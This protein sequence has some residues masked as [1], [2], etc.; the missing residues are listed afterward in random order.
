MLHKESSSSLNKKT[1]LFVQ[2]DG[3]FWVFFLNFAF[4][5]GF[6][7]HERIMAQSV[8]RRVIANTVLAQ[9]NTQFEKILKRYR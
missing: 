5:F 8:S 1:L 2:E 7:Q 4:T 6:V 3:T 9:H